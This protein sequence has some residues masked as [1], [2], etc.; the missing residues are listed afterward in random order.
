MEALR[1]GLGEPIG[2]RLGED[3]R[4]VVVVGLERGDQG[5]EAVPCGDGKRPDEVL[6]AGFLRR[7]EVG[8]G[9]VRAGPAASPSAAEG[10]GR[11]P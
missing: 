11:R 7:R 8:E 4:I 3:R 6:D 5:V 10:C 2:E 1:E 9:E